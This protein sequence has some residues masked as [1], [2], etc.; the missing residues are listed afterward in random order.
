MSSRRCY[1]QKTF[2]CI[3]FG[4][5]DLPCRSWCYRFWVQNKTAHS[6]QL[7]TAL[8]TFISQN[9]SPLFVQFYIVI[10]RVEAQRYKREDFTCLSYWLVF[11]SIEVGLPS[12]QLLTSWKLNLLLTSICFIVFQQLYICPPKMCFN[13]MGLNPCPVW[14]Y[15]TRCL[16]WDT[17]RD[18]KL[19]VWTKSTCLVQQPLPAN[20]C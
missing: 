15:I 2:C 6:L 1:K 13:T 16:I 19:N 7:D 9:S 17:W 20:S 10:L 12:Y 14:A 3:S 8:A 4:W 11:T 18:Q 5:K